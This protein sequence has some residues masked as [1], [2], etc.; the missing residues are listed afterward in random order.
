M[1][2]V[3]VGVLTGAGLSG[4]CCGGETTS[5]PG[6]GGG[7]AS[8]RPELG[9]VGGVGVGSVP[10]GGGGG[11]GRTSAKAIEAFVVSNAA[12]TNPGPNGLSSKDAPLILL[13]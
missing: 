9:F 4:G 8:S 1:F 2:F 5:T 3:V 7:G 6:G 10:G 13:M 12:K 11:G